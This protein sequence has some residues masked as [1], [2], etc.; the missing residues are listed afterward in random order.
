MMNKKSVIQTASKLHK[1][2][3][4]AEGTKLTCKFERDDMEVVVQKMATPEELRLICNLEKNG[5]ST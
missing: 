2:G 5:K 3:W 4:K 1:E